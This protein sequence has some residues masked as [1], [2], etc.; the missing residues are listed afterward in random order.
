MEC[1]HG[2]VVDV[3]INLRKGYNFFNKIL[4]NTNTLHV[5]SFSQGS[6]ECLSPLLRSMDPFRQK[7]I[8]S[9]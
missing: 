4:Y 6:M 2:V 8:I 3:L 1:L 5:A 9:G 7:D